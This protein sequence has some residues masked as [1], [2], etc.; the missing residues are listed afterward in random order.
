MNRRAIV[1]KSGGDAE[2]EGAIINGEMKALTSKE[3]DTLREE[4]AKIKKEN[5]ELGVRKV[6]DQKDFSKKIRKAKRNYT[7]PRHLTRVEEKL[8]VGWALLCLSVQEIYRRM[9]EW[10]RAA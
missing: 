3:L 1:I 4:L 5:A 8:L 7:P 2:F 10:N 6:R 9:S